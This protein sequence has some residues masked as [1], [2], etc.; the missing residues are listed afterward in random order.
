[1]LNSPPDTSGIGN[2]KDPYPYSML[3][4]LV[5]IHMAEPFYS[6][7]VSV[8]QNYIG[9]TKTLIGL[10][11]SATALVMVFVKPF[12]GAMTDKSKNKN[13][14]VSFLLFA[15]A[16]AILFFYLGYLLPEKSREVFLLVATCMLLYQIF[17]TTSNTLLEAN[18]VETLNERRG[19][20]NI[21]HI[22]LGGT[23]GYMISALISSIIIGG[24]H[25]ERMFVLVSFFCI[26]CAIWTYKLPPVSGKANKKE[27]VP[28]SEIFKNRPFLAIMLLQLTNSFGQVFFRFFNIYLVD[29][30]LNAQG[31]PNG[32]G[33]DNGVIGVLAFCNASLEIPFFWFA[34]KIQK[35]LGMRW[36]MFLAVLVT[37]TKNLLLSQVTS[38]PIILLITT[39]TGFSFVGIHF[40][41][42]NF[43]NDH[44]PK[45]MRSTAQAC[46]GLISQVCGSIIGGPLAGW[47]SDKYSTP[48]M[49]RYGALIIA[50]GGVL[51][52]IFF[53]KAMKYHNARYGPNMAPLAP[54]G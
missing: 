21:G 6:T 14:M 34:G 27:R 46:N 20:W 39:I 4:I 22:R 50:S 13:R 28:Y 26:I 52:F 30:T 37:A 32:L 2:E 23:I 8:Y 54:E 40:C 53:D 44:M 51:F 19:R 49:M 41:T 18:I 17:F 9:M 43:I 5:V 12:M 16:I 10:V 11:G 42:V 48:V 31:I 1:M 7:Y 29:K 45:K 15:N 24:D 3:F 35:K 38:Q 36:F 25:Y 33:Y 47:L